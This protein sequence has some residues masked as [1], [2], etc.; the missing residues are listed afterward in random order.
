MLSNQFDEI[1]AA[2]YP[3]QLTNTDGS[4]P[5]WGSYGAGPSNPV[6]VEYAPL[7]PA[8]DETRRSRTRRPS[9]ESDK[10][11]HSDQYSTERVSTPDGGKTWTAKSGPGRYGTSRTLQTMP[12]GLP[13]FG[14]VRSDK[15]TGN[16]GTI[17]DPNAGFGDT[18]PLWALHGASARSARNLGSPEFVNLVTNTDEPALMTPQPKVSSQR[19]N[20]MVRSPGSSQSPRTPASMDRDVPVVYEN[21][22][23]TKTLVD[24]NHRATLASITGKLFEPM[25]VL[26]P[27][28]KEA[29]M[30]QTKKIK[31]KTMLAQAHRDNRRDLLNGV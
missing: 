19:L 21:E 2:S 10:K 7:P 27:G 16:I 23:G 24:G 18:P 6:S 4:K 13:S 12:Y 9:M 8:S 31:D 28:D 17:E 30:T 1:R 26:R 29:V 3:Q 20:Q 15:L 25:R 5:S 11:R 14:E 22:Q